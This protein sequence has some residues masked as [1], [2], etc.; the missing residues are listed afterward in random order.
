MF[1]TFDSTLSNKSNEKLLNSFANNS[2][3]ELNTSIANEDTDFDSNRLE[4]ILS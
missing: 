3:Q 4:T 2:N 1:V